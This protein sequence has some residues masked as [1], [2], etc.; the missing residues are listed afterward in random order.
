M[1]ISIGL[2]Q[3][4]SFLIGGDGRV[5]EGRGW[6]TQGA[7][8]GGFNTMGYGVCFM[9]NFMEHNPSQE[10]VEA[11]HRLA[12]CMVDQEKIVREYQMFGHR[13]TKPPGGTECPGD[14]LYTTIQDW[15]GWVRV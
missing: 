15:P 12:S 2:K 11:Y 8:T 9:G 3:S 10:A 4:S 14:S 6:N 7:H 5:Y 13:Q 1:N